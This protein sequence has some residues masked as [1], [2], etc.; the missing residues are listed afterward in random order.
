MSAL[1]PASTGAS[2]TA[3]RAIVLVTVLLS[4]V[5]SFTTNVTL[6]V[7]VL[8]ASLVLVYVTA[9][10]ATCHLASVAVPPDEVSVSTPLAF[11]AMAMFPI[12]AATFVNDST[13]W[14]ATNV[15]SVTVALVNAV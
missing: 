2:F 11:V 3:V 4:F 10:N 15:V 8:G 1:G 14:P 9:R 5:P 12:V 13:S 7:V 6:R